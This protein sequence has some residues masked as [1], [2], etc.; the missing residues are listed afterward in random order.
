ME[1]EEAND[2]P[3]ALSAELHHM[4]E[5]GEG[6]AALP[7]VPLVEVMGHLLDRLTHLAQAGLTCRAWHAA[8]SDNRLWRQLCLRDWRVRRPLGVYTPTTQISLQSV[9]QAGVVF[10]E[11][12]AE[13]VR[14][15]G[16]YHAHWA[17]VSD[18]WEAF[19]RWFGTTNLSS[20]VLLP[21]ATV[22][23]ISA[24]EETLGAELPL[25]MKCS[26]FFHN[27]QDSRGDHRVGLL[28]GYSFYD[29]AIEIQLLNVNEMRLLAES[30]SR[31]LRADPDNFPQWLAH[32][33]PIARS[34]IMGKLIFVLLKELDKHGDRGNIVASS[35]DYKHTFFLESSYTE[36]LS[37]HANKLLNGEYN[38]TA[39]GI[40]LFPRPGAR[41]VGV[42]TT[43]GITV[44]A[45]P[46]FI[47][48]KSSLATSPMRFFWAYQIRMWMPS[49]CAARTSQLKARYWAITDGNG[50]IQEVRGPGVIGL[51]PVM[52]PG[53]HFVYESCCPLP[54]ASGSMRGSFLMEYKDTHEE[55]QVTV[56]EFEFFVPGLPPLV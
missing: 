53:A 54:T 34:K 3:P 43:H 11:L 24:L 4:Q 18:M 48:E 16:Q 40:D 7:W 10:K 28:G 25:D 49:D 13:M 15:Y 46:L 37:Q 32:V 26:L 52:E 21:P 20:I 12:Y 30:I 44:E 23:G 35:E 47:P 17:R 19:E 5:Q 1:K 14:E 50:R 55:F 42:A 8:A 2:T 27:G 45:A 6:W 41:G 39:E 31:H 29:H 51:Y 33:C 56:P 9:S 36:Y 38:V 22:D